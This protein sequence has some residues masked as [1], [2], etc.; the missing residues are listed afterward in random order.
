MDAVRRSCAI[1]ACRGGHQVH[2]FLEPGGFDLPGGEPRSIASAEQ[3]HPGTLEL[4]LEPDDSDILA[5]AD[6]LTV[7]PWGDLIVCEDRSGKTIRQV[8]MQEKLLPEAELDAAFAVMEERFE[9][10]D[11]PRVGVEVFGRGRAV[12]EAGVVLQVAPE[13][14]HAAVAD[15]ERIRLRGEAA[16][17]RRDQQGRGDQGSTRLSEARAHAQDR[18]PSSTLREGFDARSN[19]IHHLGVKTAHLL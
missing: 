15:L 18:S 17:R 14:P 5:G 1:G 4:F 12:G 6:N 3:D 19:D 16:R 2:P 11:V 7:A 8:A 9:G 10:G 13:D